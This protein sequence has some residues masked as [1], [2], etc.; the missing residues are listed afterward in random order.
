M[1]LSNRHRVAGLLLAAAL[2]ATTLVSAG[3]AAAQPM[4]WRDKSTPFGMVAAVGNRV[5]TDEI[6]DPH[7]GLVQDVADEIRGRIQDEVIDMLAHRRSVW[8]G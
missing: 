2:L 3:G 4:P 1:P 6:E 8:T 5:R 7:P